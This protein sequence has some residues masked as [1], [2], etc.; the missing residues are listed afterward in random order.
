MKV[1]TL[2]C[3]PASAERWGV[4]KNGRDE[5]CVICDHSA[6]LFILILE[7]TRMR[8]RTDP[9]SVPSRM[10]QCLEWDSEWVMTANSTWKA[11]TSVRERGRRKGGR[12]Q[13]IEKSKERERKSRESQERDG[14]IEVLGRKV[15]EGREGREGLQ[16]SQ[17]HTTC[18]RN[19]PSPLSS[20][21][22]ADS[23]ATEVIVLCFASVF[24][25]AYCNWSNLHAVESEPG[26]L[27][28]DV[29]ILL[30][31]WIWFCFT[32]PLLAAVWGRCCSG[33]PWTQKTRKGQEA[34]SGVQASAGPWPMVT[35]IIPEDSC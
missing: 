25:V 11:R 22:T 32:R 3:G 33:Q 6:C 23:W 2:D 26:A 20:A 29:G 7:E 9:K 16:M 4:G 21:Q 13:G 30:G 14:K 18:S 27:A 10:M 24:G 31:L 15:T 17:R 12:G 1:L 34:A 19:K 35:S 5:S 8:Q 28:E